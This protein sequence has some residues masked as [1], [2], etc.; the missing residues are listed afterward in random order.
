MK[1]IVSGCVVALLAAIPSTVTATQL[2]PCTLLTVDEIN[3]ALGRK[4]VSAGKFI[5]ESDDVSVC[6]FAGSGAGDVVIALHR[7]SANAGPAFEMLSKITAEQ[8]EASEPVPDVGDGAYFYDDELDFRVGNRIV[9]L[10][11]DRTPRTE[12]PAAVKA[13]LT[14]LGRRVTDRLRAAP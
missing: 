1:A 7:V 11:V 8:V 3:A 10:S 4:D 6:L 2:D 14:R 9:G 5:R 13:A 12:A